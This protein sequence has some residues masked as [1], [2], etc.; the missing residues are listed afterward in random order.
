[1]VLVPVDGPDDE[2]LVELAGLTDARARAATEAMLGC[3]VAEGLRTLE[4]VLDVDGSLRRLLVSRTKVDRVAALLGAHGR[5]VD[6]PALPVHVAAPDDLAAIAGFAVHR[7]VLASVDR[8]ALPDA[9][10]LVAGADRVLVVEGVNDHENVGALFRNAA[11]FGVD[12]VLLDGSCA[13][14]LYRRAVRVSV[15][16]VLR[17]PWTRVPTVADAARLLD[18]WGAPTLALTPAGDTSLA[19]VATRH[20]AGPL[21][22]VV[23]AE[24]PGLSDAALAA[25]TARVRIPVAAGVDS[26]NVATAAAVA[27]AAT[28]QLA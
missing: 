7:G 21:A 24:G 4:T 28:S 11:A 18:R 15:G 19:D 20:A 27:L 16:H 12:A 5:D 6:D 2:G 1:M 3:F 17:V 23:G 14:P 26:L 10:D 9:A 25:A 8:P 22:W 13:D